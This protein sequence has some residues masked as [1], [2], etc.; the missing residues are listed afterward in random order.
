MRENFKRDQVR[1]ITQ[2]KGILMTLTFQCD[3]CKVKLQAP[4]EDAGQSLPCP[5]C[6][7][8]LNV[9][10]FPEMGGPCPA[11]GELL[12]RS[13]GPLW[14]VILLVALFGFTAIGLFSTIEQHPMQNGILGPISVL[15]ALG[16]L[17]LYLRRRYLLCS[18]CRT[19]VSLRRRKAWEEQADWREHCFACGQPTVQ[20]LWRHRIAGGVYVLLSLIFFMKTMQAAG[21]LMQG[22]RSANASMYLAFAIM[23][24]L[25][26]ARKAHRRFMYEFWICRDCK[27][28]LVTRMRLRD[29]SS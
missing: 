11:C 5:G 22:T 18:E 4:N 16:T 20:L 26:F 19:A 3:N 28:T 25:W 27:A 13:T 21:L 1:Q 29:G 6:N 7:T 17:I 15:L 24:A 10:P 2:G 23:L 8:L 14:L 12:K 9:P